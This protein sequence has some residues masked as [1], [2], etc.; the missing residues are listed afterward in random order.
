[1]KVINLNQTD[2][3]KVTAYAA[4][5]LDDLY[6]IYKYYHY[7]LDKWADVDWDTDNIRHPASPIANM[8]ASLLAAAM[9]GDPEAEYRVIRRIFS[10]CV[11]H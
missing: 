8:D 1:M 4:S 7:K 9:L 2:F 11:L 10:D 6:D 3:A 5:I